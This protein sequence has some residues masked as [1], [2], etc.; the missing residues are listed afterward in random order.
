MAAPYIPAKDSLFDNWLANFATLITASPSTYGLVAGD[1]LV[2]QGAYDD[3]SAAYT[4]ATDPSTRTK[5][6]VAAKDAQRATSSAIARPYAINVRNNAG[7]SNED[8]LDLGL[9]IPDLT[10]TPVPPPVTS[11]SLS[12]V[13][14]ISLQHQLNFRDSAFP[15]LKRKPVGA[16]SLQLW[17]AVGVV[18]ATDPAQA[19]FY[20]NVTKT[21]FVVGFDSGDRGKHCTYF[22]RW[23]T[24]SGPGGIAQFGPWSDAL[25]VIVI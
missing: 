14:A 17:R 21:P 7:V 23:A 15:L 22:G 5:P 19:S 12:L 13:N 18:A 3:W 16:T 4:L 25:D 24:R 9:T 11:P 20:N 10:P 2:I 1:A 6:T 8:K